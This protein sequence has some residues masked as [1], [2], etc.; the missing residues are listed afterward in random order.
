MIEELHA[1]VPGGR[2]GRVLRDSTK[3]RLAFTYEPDWQK[4]PNSYPI[5][6]SMPL[7]AADHEQAKIEPFLWGLLPDNDGIL[8]RWGE[9]F[10][11]SP[12][13]PFKL[14]SQVGEDC[15][16]ALQLVVP[17]RAIELLTNPGSGSLDWIDD[18]Q[19]A[20][21]VHL[22]LKDHSVSRT[23]GDA[24]QFSLAGAQP[25]TAFYLDPVSNRWAI[26]S[27]SIPTTHIFKPATGI[28]DG[29]A[30]NEHFC[31]TLAGALGMQVVPSRIQYFGDAAV[32]VVERYDRLRHGEGVT[33]IHQEDTCQ[34]LARMP[35]SKYQSEGGP[36][37]KEIVELIRDH[38]TDRATDESRFLDALIFNWLISG[39]D[40]H[41]KN[42]SLLIAPHG[43]VRLAP[44]Y[45]LS[46]AL[47]Y[48]KSIDPRDARLAMKIGHQYHIRQIGAR[49]W[50]KTAEEL[51]LNGEMVRSRIL[52]FAQRIP[53]TAQTVGQSIRTQGIKHEVIARLVDLVA[54]RAADCGKALR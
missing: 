10:K 20:E 7:A 44:L 14:L 37:A 6:L 15:A 53:D 8:K 24:G 25:K 39:T 31:I 49:E 45:D 26:P 18:A 36:S 38:S 22:L 2:M 54:K 28:Y 29:Y 3:N 16:G 43:Q 19:I 33:R 12:R 41:A 51:R 5:S 11:V 13:N 32:I 34:A 52:Y 42:Y 50:M 35:Q 30:E 1:I 40:A 27:G 4:G 21:R 9:R 47:P 17:E 48:E 46:S 23:A